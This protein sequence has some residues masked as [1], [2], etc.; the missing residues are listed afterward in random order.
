MQITFFLLQSPCITR[1]PLWV[2]VL[3]CL[4]AGI[5][6]LS[7]H[8]CKSLLTVGLLS[9]GGGGITSETEL[10]RVWW[11]CEGVR[12]MEL[13]LD[14]VPI[15]VVL[16]SF[17]A[18]LDSQEDKLYNRVHFA[19]HGPSP[20]CQ[21]LFLCESRNVW[22]VTLTC[23]SLLDM[24]LNS[25]E[26]ADNT[27]WHARTVTGYVLC[28]IKCGLQIA[29]RTLSVTTVLPW[30]WGWVGTM[31]RCWIEPLRF[32]L[33]MLRY[34]VASMYVSVSCCHGNPP[35][36]MA[37]HMVWVLLHWSVGAFEVLNDTHWS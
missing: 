11:N 35:V 2:N 29:I 12:S 20:V 1:H 21:P 4:S 10:G 36:A 8:Q 27:R 32:A 25:P 23:L 17:L 31:T 7:E 18:T 22:H 30:G 13:P 5:Q 33:K 34:R 37:I 9:V 15:P 26:R 6:R 16:T 14:F 24:R 28:A 19:W 3:S